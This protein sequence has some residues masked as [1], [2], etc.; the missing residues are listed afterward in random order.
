MQRVVELEAQQSM[1][2]NAEVE[3][4]LRSALEELDE[5]K[6]NRERQ[7]D[8]MRDYM[9]KRDSY[10][11]PLPPLFLSFSTFSIVYIPRPLL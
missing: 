2:T 11:A 10:P 7:M 8:I 4:K 6:A 3:S 5:L 1:N 9:S